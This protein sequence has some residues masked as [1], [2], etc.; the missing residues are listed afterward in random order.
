VT[1]LYFVALRLLPRDVRDVHGAEMAAVFE[2]LLRERRRRDGVTGVVR[3]ATFELCALL[4]FAWC[5]RRGTRPPPRIDE[6]VLAWPA[7]NERK[8][9]MRASVL[10]DLRYAARLLARTPGFTLICIVTMAVAVGANTA[11]FSL[12]HGV[13]LKPLPFPES[14]RLVVLGH[15]TDGDATISS[16]TPGNFYD[17]QSRMTAVDAIAGFAYTQRVV[18]RGEF[19]ERTLGALSVGSVFDVLGRSAQD[20]RTL[21]AADD[22][23]GA[24]AVVVLAEGFARRLFGERQVVGESIRIGGGA[25][26]VI[27]VM[28][29]DFAFPDYDAQYWVSARFDAQFRQNRDQYFLLAVARLDPDASVEQSLS[30]LNTVMDAIRRDYPQHTQN[31]TGAVLP[32]KEFVVDGSGTRLWMLL[33]GV[34]VVLMIACA[35]IANLLLARGS[36]RRREMA[37]R[38]ALGARSTRLVRQM[39]T[40]S[41]LL[42]VLGGAVGIVLGRALL[43]L[44]ILWLPQNLPR[45]DGV[46]LDGTVLAVTATASIVCG[47][48]FGL[49][50]ALQLSRDGAANAIRQ[51]IRETGRTDRVRSGLVIAQV[52]LSL[53]LLAGAGLLARSFDNLSNVRPGFEPAG[54]LTFNVSLPGAVYREPSARLAYFE[55]AVEQLRRL[56][57]VT[58]VALSSTLPVAGRG[59]GAW[60][61]ILD[62]PLPVDQTPPGIPYR[63]V[64]PSYFTTIGIPLR[65]GRVLSDDDGLRGARAVVISE[66]VERRFWPNESALGKRIYLGAPDNRLFED[67]EIVGVVGDVKQT[68]L[69]EATS[70]AVYIPHRLM[71]SM[72]TFSF[73]LRTAQ[74]PTS[75]ASAARAEL[76]KIDPSVPVHQLRSMAEIVAQSLAPARSSLYLLGLFA[77]MALI[78][79]TIGVFGVLSYTVSQRRA[80]MAIRVAL[81]ATSR[82]VLMLVLGHGLRHVAIGIA[83]GLVLCVSLARYIQGL[84][85]NVPPV[86]PLTLVAV[87]MLLA[88]VASVAVY[89]P[90]RRATTVDPVMVLRDP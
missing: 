12:V 47:L 69:D 75:L 20:G 28:P 85:F 71:P 30:Q 78:L 32:L 59:I 3:A 10:Q 50:P 61:N 40:E 70:E 42:A 49:W 63:V 83:I 7:E 8:L 86:D 21:S 22:I 67:A 9:P 52:A 89:V 87:S 84:L 25:F 90:G 79:A 4:R 6:R 44:L 65:R 88:V 72:P 36:A 38:H 48:A 1:R 29:S 2:Q 77:V 60:F 51:G 54:L 11:V 17:W 34:V 18:E 62:R 46:T 39:L 64:T 41:L 27:G 33:G 35:N 56:P 82:S 55:R 37:V 81:G 53:T 73:A 45:A 58:T 43:Q 15:H 31:A 68:G 13:M 76:R 19:A 26:T 66:A 74:E 24:P 23:F 57:G 16:T 5:A 80:E 14:D